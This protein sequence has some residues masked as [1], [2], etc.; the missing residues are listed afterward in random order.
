MA[1]RTGVVKAQPWSRAWVRRRR[2]YSE[3]LQPLCAARDSMAAMK[4]W[5]RLTLTLEV[6][7]GMGLVAMMGVWLVGW[8]FLLSLI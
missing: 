2:M 3:R 4:S 7:S 8:L 6:P 5:S 1:C